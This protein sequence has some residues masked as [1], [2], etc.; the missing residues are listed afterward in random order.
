MRTVRTISA[1]AL[2]LGLLGGSTLAV[3][4]QDAAVDAMAPAYFTGDFDGGPDQVIP[5]E[6]TP[7]PNGMR[8]EGTQ[9]LR[10]PFEVSDPRIAGTLS[11]AANGAGAPLPTGFS[12]LESR[13]WT[14]TNDGGSWTG[15]GTNVYTEVD[16]G[17]TAMDLETM[18][19]EGAGDYA[20]LYAYVVTDWLAESPQV[21]GVIYA[22][23]PAPHP[24]PLPTQ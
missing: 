22:Q 15:L 20:G 12:S 3:A 11:V 21:K 10:I 4:A 18:V 6:E 2:A 5:G 17:Q 24:E 8:M 16:G 7:T 23:E 1:A 13:S 19:L 14:I 9:F